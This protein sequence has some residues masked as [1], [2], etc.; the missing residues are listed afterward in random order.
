[1][2]LGFFSV[3]SWFPAFSS[4]TLFVCVRAANSIIVHCISPHSLSERI[5]CVCRNASLSAILLFLFPITLYCCDKF[6]I[7]VKTD[8]FAMTDM[9]SSVLDTSFFFVLLPAQNN[10]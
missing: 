2:L 10:T 3:L 8:S 7:A 6:Q 9:A 4:I 5:H 1:M